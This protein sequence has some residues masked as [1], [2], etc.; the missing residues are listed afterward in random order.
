MTPERVPQRI[1]LHAVS[2]FSVPECV[3]K[4]KS[5][6][7]MRLR[8]GNVRLLCTVSLFTGRILVPYRNTTMWRVL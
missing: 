5:T 2:P 4:G 3:H 6:Y 7:L 1:I 8:S